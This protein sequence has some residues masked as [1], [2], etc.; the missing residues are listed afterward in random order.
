MFL[1]EAAMQP[2]LKIATQIHSDQKNLLFHF[3]SPLPLKLAIWCPRLYICRILLLAIALLDASV[4]C[5]KYCNRCCGSRYIIRAYFDR[6]AG[7]L[8]ALLGQS[9]VVKKN[10]ILIMRYVPH[11]DLLYI[12]HVEPA[13]KKLMVEPRKS[14]LGIMR[15]IHISWINQKDTADFSQRMC[16]W[17]QRVNGGLN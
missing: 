17:L 7:W 13:K 15:G 2:S 10:M 6:F 12:K 11:R 16:I 8:A 3:I 5:Q 9:Q 1:G 4:W 14:S